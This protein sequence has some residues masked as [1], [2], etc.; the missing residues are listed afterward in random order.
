MLSEVHSKGCLAEYLDVLH[1]T[2]LIDVFEDRCIK[3]DDIVLMFSIDGAQLYTKK[4][5]TCWIY[6]WVLFNL[7]PSL[8]YKKSFMFIG[9]FIP[10][11]NN[12]KNID[13]FLLLGLQH[14]VSLQKD[15]LC[16]WDGALQCKL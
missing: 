11:L 15:G 5:S 14:L 7:P 3:D 13:S 16:I 2:D 4:V 10:G 9:G 12:P 1:S 8:R 6:I